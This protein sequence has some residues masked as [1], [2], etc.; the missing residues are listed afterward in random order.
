MMLDWLSAKEGGGIPDD[1]K[2]E[3]CAV[4]PVELS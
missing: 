1:L 3:A 4:R 2:F